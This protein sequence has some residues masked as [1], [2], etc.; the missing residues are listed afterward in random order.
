MRLFAHDCSQCLAHVIAGEEYSV[1]G[2]SLSGE[3]F[4]TF[5]DEQRTVGVLFAAFIDETLLDL[6]LAAVREEIQRA[7]RG[8]DV[9]G[10][11]WYPLTLV[12][13]IVFECG[14]DLTRFRAGRAGDLLSL[15]SLG[16]GSG[17]VLRKVRSDLVV[18]LYALFNGCPVAKLR[19]VPAGWDC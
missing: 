1:T 19:V 14:L 3:L 18:L 6:V 10:Q 9:A 15:F 11:L 12:F 8:L 17:R 13:P 5:R 7:R 4:P 16:F 2:G